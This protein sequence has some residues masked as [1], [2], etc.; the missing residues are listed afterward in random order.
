MKRSGANETYWNMNFGK[1]PAEELYDLKADPDCVNNLATT[2]THESKKKTLSTQMVS[3][4]EQQGDPR[5]MGNGK[6]FDD[7][8]YSD[9][10]TA[11]FY[12]RYLSGN[13]PRAGWVSEGDFEKETLD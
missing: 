1:R 5:M 11:H 4:L 10:R 9:S 2:R 7:Y 13:R 6:L 12:E 8:P 3:E